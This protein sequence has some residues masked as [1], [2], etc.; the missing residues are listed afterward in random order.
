MSRF[1]VTDPRAQ[2][3]DTETP[4]TAIIPISRSSLDKDSAVVDST[5]KTIR[6]REFALRELSSIQN[7][8]LIVMENTPLHPETIKI[9]RALMGSPRV[10][11]LTE[12][13]IQSCQSGLRYG[14]E[15]GDTYSLETDGKLGPRTLDGLLAKNPE[16]AKSLGVSRLSSD[17]LGEIINFRWEPSLPPASDSL[18]VRRTSLGY[19]G[20][21]NLP[22]KVT[23]LPL[24]QQFGD[25]ICQAA[26]RYK[27]PVCLIVAVMNQESSGKK[28]AVSYKGA[29]GLMQLMP[30]T[31]RSLG[32]KDIFDPEQNIN[33]GTKY[34]RALMDRFDNNMELVLAGYNAGE[35]AVARF[36]N[37]V[38]PY[39]ETEN[40][41]AKI[42]RHYGSLTEAG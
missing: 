28:S 32:V 19:S 8:N 25:F 36:G 22:A 41:V 23:Q 7:G 27:V 42:M 14:G 1:K 30:A 26:E 9:L 17:R 15:R 5:Q 29:R 13:E 39:R 10:G 38:P 3:K 33:G 34:L 12:N 16:L 21:Q 24:F 6:A 4:G 11:K 20:N 40:Y 18:G 35:N 31:A 37:K 2:V